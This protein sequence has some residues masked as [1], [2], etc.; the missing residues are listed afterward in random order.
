MTLLAVALIFTAVACSDKKPAYSDEDQ[1]S[2]FCLKGKGNHVSIRPGKDSVCVFPDG[3]ECNVQD[4]LKGQ[5][6]PGDS[7]KKK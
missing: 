3:S 4:Y 7:A 5:C 6:K 2:L 1:A